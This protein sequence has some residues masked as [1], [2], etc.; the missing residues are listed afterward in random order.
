MEGRKTVWNTVLV[1]AAEPWG[2]LDAVPGG[3]EDHSCHAKCAGR[4]NREPSRLRS[5]GRGVTS[6]LAASRGQPPN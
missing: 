1:R 5:E 3:G 6:S 4:W 2:E